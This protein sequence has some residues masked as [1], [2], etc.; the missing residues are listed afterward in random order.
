M[1]SKGRTAKRDINDILVVNSSYTDL[2]YLVKRLLDEKMLEN[3]CYDCGIDP[4][5][6]GNPLSLQ[7]DHINGVH[8]DHRIE[9]LR[10]LCPNCHSQTPT[11]GGRNIKYVK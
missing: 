5:W 9:N 6:M 1:V 7:L 2:R 3:K 10:L 8:N 11:F 4:N